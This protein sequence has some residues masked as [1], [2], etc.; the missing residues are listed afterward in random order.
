MSTMEKKGP[1]SWKNIFNFDTNLIDRT[2]GL[3]MRQDPQLTIK[4]EEIY[5]LELL[6]LTPS[7]LELHQD[8]EISTGINHHLY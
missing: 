2:T 4:N 6:L 7:H 3:I 5:H 1:S 8:G